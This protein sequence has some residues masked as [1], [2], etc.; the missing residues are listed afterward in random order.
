MY[1]K[2]MIRSGSSC[3]RRFSCVFLCRFSDWQCASD[4][5][6]AGDCWQ[7]GEAD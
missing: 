2:W 6:G 7:S 1:S 5:H 4:P 3:H